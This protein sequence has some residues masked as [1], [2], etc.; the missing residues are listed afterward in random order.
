VIQAGGE[1]P[2]Q[3]IGKALPF[4]A[5]ALRCSKSDHVKQIEQDDHGDRNTQK[6]QKYA[7]HFVLQSLKDQRAAP[8]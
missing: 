5:N 7:T 3:T 6:P 1:R 2:A 4:P 8:F